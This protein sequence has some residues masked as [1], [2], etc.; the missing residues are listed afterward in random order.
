MK[1]KKKKSREIIWLTDASLFFVFS[2]H[3]LN[4]NIDGK[5]PENIQGN[6]IVFL[7]KMMN[8]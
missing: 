4:E 7:A 5:Y 2:K 8:E 6:C 1:L 3:M